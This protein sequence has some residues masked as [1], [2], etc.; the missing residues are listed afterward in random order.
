MEKERAFNMVPGVET[1]PVFISFDNNIEEIICT[2][3]VQ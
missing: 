3:K 1:V 2:L